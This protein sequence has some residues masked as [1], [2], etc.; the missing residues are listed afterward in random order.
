MDDTQ[1]S[2]TQLGEAV[3]RASAFRLHP[4]GFFYFE[5]SVGPG[6]TRRVHIWL[7][8][9]STS[10]EIAARH[11]HPFDL[12]SIVLMGRLSNI[13]YEFSE[14][15][16]GPVHELQVHYGENESGLMATGRRGSLKTVA[17]FFSSPGEKAYSVRAGVIHRADAVVRPCVTVL[18]TTMQ[19]ERSYSYGKGSH[20]GAFDRRIVT[21]GEARSIGELLSMVDRVR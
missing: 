9:G 5:E 16:G 15:P 7:A 10:P 13:V 8:G 1:I 19:S 20:E 3:R 12:E 18:V 4:L 21:P 11:S 14:D 2:F 6:N 17:S